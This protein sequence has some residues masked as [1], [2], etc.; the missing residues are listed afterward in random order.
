MTSCGSG[1]QGPLN[2]FTAGLSGRALRLRQ[3]QN[4]IRQRLGRGATKGFPLWTKQPSGGFY[5]VPVQGG[6]GNSNSVCFD[7]GRELERLNQ[8]SRKD[9]L[10][11]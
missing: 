1:V 10:R 5:T 11:N 2:T 7:G 9:S 8:P 6:L 3:S 4:P